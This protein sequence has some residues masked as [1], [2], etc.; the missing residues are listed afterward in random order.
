MKESLNRNTNN[1]PFGKKNLVMGMNMN[2]VI[3]CYIVIS[4]DSFVFF[5]PSLFFFPRV[6]DLGWQGR[7][8]G[9]QW[10]GAGRGKYI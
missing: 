6:E 10:V 3:I 4:L 7:V 5:F 9:G 2:M 1:P 8:D